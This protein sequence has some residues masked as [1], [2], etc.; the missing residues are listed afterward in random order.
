M[1]HLTGFAPLATEYDGFIVDLWGVMHDGISPY[2][3]AMDCLRRLQTAGKRVVLLSNA[4]RRASRVARGLRA[5]GI[6]DG[7]YN[8]VLTSGE[9]TRMALLE[10][11][12]PWIARLG[13]RVLHL[14]PEKDRNL[15]EGLDLD[16]AADPASADFVLNTGP[17]DDDGETGPEPYLPLLRHCAGLGL[18]MLC[19][20]PDLEIVRGGARIICAGLLARF[21]AQYGGEVRSIGKPYPEVYASVFAMLGVPLARVLAVGDALATDIAGAKV[22]GIAS[23]WVLGGIHAELI[24]DNHALADAE[25]ANAGLAPIATIPSFMW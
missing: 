18:P 23:C 25:A 17:N 4:P 20:N 19:A 11:T 8:A 2:D 22:A 15:I 13:R 7:C 16:L 10:R 3:G 14:G 12:D 24:G 1:R 5:M 6:P 21:Y 9:A